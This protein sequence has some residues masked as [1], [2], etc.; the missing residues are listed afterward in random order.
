MAIRAT[1]LATGNKVG[2]SSTQV[3]VL[4]ELGGRL[5]GYVQGKLASRLDC[6]ECVRDLR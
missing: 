2:N 5:N 1:P 3:G 6:I 4:D